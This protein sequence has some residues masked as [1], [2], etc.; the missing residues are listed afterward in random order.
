MYSAI[1]L[2]FNS[3]P[4]SFI[5]YTIISKKDSKNSLTLFIKYAKNMCRLFSIR[6]LLYFVFSNL[7]V[8]TGISLLLY[9]ILFRLGQ[10]LSASNNINHTAGI[11]SYFI[12]NSNLL[13]HLKIF[14]TSY[15]IHVKFLYSI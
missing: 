5:F 12:S 2:V 1:T 13:C 7:F 10:Y 3:K 8:N 14:I 15:N 4:I 6:A 9:I 11:S